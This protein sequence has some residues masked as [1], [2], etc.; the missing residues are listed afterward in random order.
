MTCAPLLQ[1]LFHGHSLVFWL[2]LRGGSRLEGS[3][4]GPGGGCGAAVSAGGAQR[5]LPA[6][7]E[8]ARPKQKLVSALGLGVRAAKGS[9]T[10]RPCPDH[11]APRPRSWEDDDRKWFEMWDEN[12]VGTFTNLGF[13]DEGT[14]KSCLLGKG[15]RGF[16]GNHCGLGRT[17]L[18]P[19]SETSIYLVP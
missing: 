11:V 6:L 10:E 2:A 16:P 12:T 15:G 9:Q 14:G 19:L 18:P 3:G 5:L 13:Q 1:M 8:E 7:P 4:R 17:Q